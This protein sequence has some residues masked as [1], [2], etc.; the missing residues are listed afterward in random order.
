MGRKPITTKE[1]IKKFK[2]IHGKKYN[3]SKVLYK[4]IKEKVEIICPIH[5]PFFQ[6]PFNHLQGKGCKLC[7]Y[8]V[9]SKK[10]SS[11]IKEFIKKA[12]KIHKNKFDY[13]NVNYINNTTKVKITCKKHGPFFQ[14]PNNHL[15]GNGCLK[16]QPEYLSCLF[17][18]NDENVIKDFKKIHDDR[19]DYSKVVYGK[20]NREKVKIICK[21][22]GMFWQTPTGHL[23]GKG[24]PKCHLSKGEIKIENFLKQ[25]DIDFISHKKFDD[26]VNN[27]TNKKLEFDFYIPSKNLL[28][29]YDGAQHFNLGFLNKHKVTKKELQYIQFKDK[30]K[31]DYAKSK[32]I[33]LLRIKYNQIN[34]IDN[35]LTDIF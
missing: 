35:L 8:I 4:F 33:R 28:I 27:T 10:Q 1:C 13:S 23:N 22:H 20:N 29:E 3:Y 5:G 19:Y 6:T 30:L 12:K 32:N 17:R 2:K 16:C 9:V 25:N 18:K 31:N 24:C 14:T 26:C 15:Q 11:N 34:S 7:G 21:K